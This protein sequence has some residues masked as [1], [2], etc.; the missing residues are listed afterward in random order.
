MRGA[1]IMENEGF[2]LRK[3]PVF[4]ERIVFRIWVNNSRTLFEGYYQVTLPIFY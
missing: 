3:R 1:F 2:G 4:P